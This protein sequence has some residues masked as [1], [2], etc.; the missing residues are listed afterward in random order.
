[1][2]YADTIPLGFG[3]GPG[4]TLQVEGYLPGQSEDMTIPR[5]LVAPGFFSVMRIPIL[6][7]RE[8][9]RQDD[10]NTAPVVI[11]NQSFARRFFKD[12]NP[13][14]RKIRAWGKWATVVGLVKDTKQYTLIEPPRPYFYASAQQIAAP[15]VIAFYVRT[16][17]HP[18]QMTAALRRE[19]AA[20]DPNAGAFDAMPLAEYIAAPLFPQ[21]MA[22]GLLSALGALSMLL[23]AV[24]LY[25]VMAY[26]VSQRT[27][28]IGIRMALGARPGDVLG[29]VVRQG[30]VLTLKGLAAGVGVALAATSLVASMLVNVSATDP[31]VFA[32]A[33]LFLGLVA[34]AASFLPARRATR[35]DPVFALR[36]Q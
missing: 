6:D 9:T 36:H 35:I 5:S 3:L 15:P 26:A 27:H 33:A 29:M 32:G 11:V 30:M 24:G 1:V 4:A 28:E 23:A 21:R 13:I 34:L 20:I 18:D 14:G 19:A 2:S 8:F 10:L 12:R 25:S 16:T 31:L 22:A 17:G 7:G